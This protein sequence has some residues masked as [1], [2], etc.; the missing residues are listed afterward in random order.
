VKSLIQL[1]EKE[2]QLGGVIFRSKLV[3]NHPSVKKKE[4]EKGDG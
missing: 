3:L 2:K 1:G 4:E